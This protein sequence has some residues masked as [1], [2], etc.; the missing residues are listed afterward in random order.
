[1]FWKGDKGLLCATAPQNHCFALLF[2][3]IITAL[4]VTLQLESQRRDSI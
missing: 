4:G 3:K 2:P 1:M